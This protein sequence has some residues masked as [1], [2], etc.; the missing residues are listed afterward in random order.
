LDLEEDTSI[1]D[2]C[3]DFATMA[4]DICVGHKFFYFF[5]CVLADLDGIKLIKC[6]AEILTLGEDSVSTESGLKTLQ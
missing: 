4:D 2:G 6:E 3:E 5:V 1:V